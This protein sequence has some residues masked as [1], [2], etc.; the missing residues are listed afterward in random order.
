[1]LNSQLIVSCIQTDWMLLSWR[2]L[3]NV[4]M[5]LIYLTLLNPEMKT[6]TCRNYNLLVVCR[7]KQAQIKM[8]NSSCQE[9]EQVPIR[10]SAND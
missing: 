6:C 1:M 9:Q 10:H 7:M 4:D 5:D 2:R 3:A 8:S